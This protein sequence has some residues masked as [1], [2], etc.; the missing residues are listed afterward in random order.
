MNGTENCAVMRCRLD[1]QWGIKAY[2]PGMMNGYIADNVIMG[3]PRFQTVI[4]G[5]Q[6][7]A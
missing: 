4:D 6:E 1:G 2:K 7:S 3:L 5:C